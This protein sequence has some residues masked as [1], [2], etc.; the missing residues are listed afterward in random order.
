MATAPTSPPEAAPTDL[1][2]LITNNN[3]QPETLVV[4]PA[5]STPEVPTM[6]SENH[7]RVPRWLIGVGVG[8]LL[9]V[10]VA[11]AYFILGIGQAPKSTSQPAT[12]VS[13][14]QIKPPLPIATPAPTS[15]QPA[16]GSASFGELQGGQ[17]ATSAADL[18]RQRQGR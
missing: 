7:K 15:E 12:T 18:L 1:S 9:A 3:S 16:T 10:V 6:P 17:Q 14:N 8:L 4:P 11:T 13:Q 5:S 2:H